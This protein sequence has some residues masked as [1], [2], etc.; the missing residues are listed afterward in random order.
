M[1]QNKYTSVIKGFLLTIY[2]DR[3]V[4]TF[5][6]MNKIYLKKMEYV[7]NEREKAKYSLN[8]PGEICD[9]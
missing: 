3:I 8:R 4:V 9:Q 1:R 2:M 5:C 6:S 7:M